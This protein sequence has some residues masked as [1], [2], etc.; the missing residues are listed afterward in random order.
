MANTPNWIALD[1]SQQ[2]APHAD[3]LIVEDDA[4]IA[5]MYAL[6]LSMAGLSVR[7]ASSGE[8]A[9]VDAVV[10]AQQNAGY[11]VIVLDLELPGMSGWT[12]LDELRQH[13]ETANVPVILLSNSTVDVDEVASHGASEWHA[14]YRTTPSQLVD[15]VRRLRLNAA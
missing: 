6:E 12:T 10:E 15:Y 3:V 1:R 5:D 4:A 11:G 7:V 8:S 14:K 2:P 9:V 13:A